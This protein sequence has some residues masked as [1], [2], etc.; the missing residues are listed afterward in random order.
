MFGC[1]FFS[2]RGCGMRKKPRFYDPTKMSSLRIHEPKDLHAR[3]KFN[4]QVS[5]LCGERCKL[6]RRAEGRRHAAAEVA[7]RWRRRRR[8]AGGR[9][10]ARADAG[11]GWREDIEWSWH[12]RTGWLAE[13]PRGMQRQ[14]PVHRRQRRRLYA[15]R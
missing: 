15:A 9:G 11:A 6:P 5:Q 4:A 8:R 12:C 1:F 10:T 14:S 13:R 2:P 7:A 3:A